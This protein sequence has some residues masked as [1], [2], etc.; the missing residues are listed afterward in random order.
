MFTLKL[1]EIEL[2]PRIEEDKHFSNEDK[3]ELASEVKDYIQEKYADTYKNPLTVDRKV[4]DAIRDDKGETFDDQVE[5][6]GKEKDVRFETYEKVRNEIE[7]EVK[8]KYAPEI[9]QLEEE[10]DKKIHDIYDEYQLKIDTM[11][12]EGRKDEVKVLEEERSIKEDDIRY[13][14]M[15][16]LNA[17]MDKRFKEIEEKVNNAS[18]R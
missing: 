14:G 1:K 7:E 15:Q 6:E 11:K 12:E 18:N 17:L 13:E 8:V 9:E 16:K 10:L 3:Y 2:I 4:N 5:R